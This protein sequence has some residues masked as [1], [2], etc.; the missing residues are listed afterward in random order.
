MKG[1][2]LEGFK[3]LEYEEKKAMN[4]LSKKKKFYYL[5]IKNQSFF[6]I[7]IVSEYLKNSLSN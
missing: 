7:L 2:T 4:L 3:A 1:L 6:N 5:F